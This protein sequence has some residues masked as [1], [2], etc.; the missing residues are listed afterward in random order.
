V[1]KTSRSYP[2]E[3]FK[4]TASRGLSE[5]L[6]LLVDAGALM[7]GVHRFLL[8]ARPDLRRVLSLL[9]E[10]L[11]QPPLRG[12][13]LN[14]TSE[15]LL[16]L[17]S[18]S[19]RSCAGQTDGCRGDVPSG[20]WIKFLNWWRDVRWLDPFITAS[21]AMPVGIVLSNRATGQGYPTLSLELRK[22]KAGY[23]IPY[24]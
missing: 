16:R 17:D 12:R 21:A 13:P 7:D 22:P 20:L 19:S 15:A 9:R 2:T 10:Y 24:Y 8:L 4:R 18:S 14:T 1:T 5:K 23:S 3:A 11:Q 6:L